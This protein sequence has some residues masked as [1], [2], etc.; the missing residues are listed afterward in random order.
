M[1]GYQLLNQ[2]GS[3]GM[4]SSLF[5]ILSLFTENVKLS[6]QDE[7]NHDDDDELESIS[8]ASTQRTPPRTRPGR[9]NSDVSNLSLGT[10]R[11]PTRRPSVSSS[12]ST[13]H[14]EDATSPRAQSPHRRSQSPL[15]FPQSARIPSG[16]STRP[17]S[18]V[19]V[20]PENH[21]SA[22]ARAAE[23]SSL[24]VIPA[25]A[26][27][28]LTKKF[29]KATA[30]IVQGKN[31]RVY[32]ASF[33]YAELREVILTRFSRV[34][35]N[36]AHNYLGL[37]TEVLRTEKAINDI[38]CHPLPPM[39]YESGLRQ[40]RQRFDG[41]AR[42]EEAESD[43]DYFSMNSPSLNPSQTSIPG[44]KPHL[45]DDPRPRKKYS[46]VTPF[47]SV[48]PHQNVHA[49]DLH[50]T[51][52]NLMESS[53]PLPRTMSTIRGSHAHGQHRELSPDRGQTGAPGVRRVVT[54]DFDLRD[55]VMSCI[56]K[57]IGLIQ[58]PISHEDSAEASPAFTPSESRSAGP[59]KSS[60]GS[61]SLLEIGDD[62]SSNVTG[63]SS[64]IMTDGYM[65]GLDN[66]VEILFFPAGS[67][68]AKA[69]EQNTGTPTR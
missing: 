66:E 15:P 53:R 58:P 65:S 33:M 2:V 46:P 26:F 18:N 23:D 24:A 57:S 39:F 54:D 63:A 50:T 31:V 28:R 8:V 52:G 60:F 27:R 38:A 9:S 14:Q 6:W 41:V 68:L 30:H 48:T 49:G 5:T 36:A 17:K 42:Q 56:A 61:L 21:Y 62:T 32:H 55:E 7:D 22:V 13:V 64:S 51:V 34:T 45:T 43:E 44:S 1:N 67:V 29:P 47:K 59:F 19:S 40:L 69:G 20:E 10:L 11:S 37:T 25:E 12:G 35:F 3:G 4:L 16:T